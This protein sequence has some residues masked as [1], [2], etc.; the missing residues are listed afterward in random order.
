MK[1]GIA[2]PLSLAAV[3]GGVRTQV[4]QTV[5]HVRSLGIDAEIIHSD[6]DHFDFDIV[7]IFSASSENIGIAKQAKN[8]GIPLILSPVFYSKRSA[9]SISNVLKVENILSKIGTGIRSEYGVK[10]EI[11]KLADLL[12]PNTHEEK[13]LVQ[14]AFGINESKVKVIPNGVESRFQFATPDLF[15]EQYGLE[16]FILFAGQAGAARKNVIQLLQVAP[17]FDKEIVIIGDFYDDDYSQMCINLAEKSSNIHL[18]PTLEHSDPLLESAYAACEIFCLPSLFETPGI[19]AMEAALAGA[20]IVIT[21]NG[22]TI[23]YFGDEAFY[24]D[25][26]STSSLNSAL[27]K[28]IHSTNSSELKTRILELYTWEKVA[29]QTVLAYRTLIN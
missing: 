20:K 28:A 12:L 4:N 17:N 21:Q 24:S 5:Q 11:C 25:P 26:T 9:N 29:E 14:N 6:H 19:A 7:H 2:A 15:K 8:H 22:G 10:A 16:N 27:S 13:V 3:N 18:I 1:V 23:Q